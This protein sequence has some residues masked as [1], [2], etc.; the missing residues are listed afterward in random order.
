[1]VGSRSSAWE[2]TSHGRLTLERLWTPTALS[3]QN[4]GLRLTSHVTSSGKPTRGLSLS[5][6]GD[7]Y[8][9]LPW[10]ST[11][12]GTEPSGVSA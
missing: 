10:V 7:N 6:L 11:T 4:L 5:L 1:M 2:T 9:Y 12:L 8:H 3:S